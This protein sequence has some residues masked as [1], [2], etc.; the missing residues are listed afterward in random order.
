MAA[1]ASFHSLFKRN[2]NVIGRAACLAVNGGLPVEGNQSAQVGVHMYT[3]Q[4]LVLYTLLAMH[5]RI[6]PLCR[7]G[8]GDSGFGLGCDQINDLWLGYIQFI[9]LVI[10]AKKQIMFV[11]HQSWDLIKFQNRPLRGFCTNHV[12]IMYRWPRKK[13]HV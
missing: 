6:R 9:S 4:T 1:P 2:S 8:L 10:I 11:R 3:K 7:D 12:F 13:K 5:F